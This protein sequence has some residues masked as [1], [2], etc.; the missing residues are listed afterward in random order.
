VVNAAAETNDPV[1]GHLN[2]T[3]HLDV[4]KQ[5]HHASTAAPRGIYLT[6]TCCG[7]KEPTVVS[8]AC[9]AMADM[10]CLCVTNSLA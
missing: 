3:V 2:R 9:Y 7:G 4:M 1:C 5:K 6:T 8:C 10:H